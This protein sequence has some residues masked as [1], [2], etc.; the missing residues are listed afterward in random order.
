MHEYGEQES[1]NNLVWRLLV[2]PA[3][4]YFIRKYTSDPDVVIDASITVCPPIADRYRRER[5]LDPIIVFN[6]PKPVD[7]PARE[8]MRDAE[9]IRLIHHGFAK[10]GRGLHHLVRA[11]ALTDQRFVLDF[12][13][14]EDNPGYIDHLRRL[15][16]QLAPGR[17]RFRDPVLPWEIVQCVS[18]Y[19]V[20]LC[21]IEPS[22][23]NNLMMLPNKL[24]EYIQGGLA[25][26][27]GPSPA[28]VELVQRHR[29]GIVTRSFEPSDLAEALN[30][31]TWQQ[32][33]EMKKAARGA[34]TVLNADVEM[35]KVVVL[36]QQLLDEGMGQREAAARRL[37]HLARCKPVRR[38][39]AGVLLPDDGSPPN[40]S[41]DG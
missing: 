41:G 10:R 39:G 21:V 9:R 35:A 6:A 14:V 34:A 12:M 20:G 7:V 37:L 33:G 30:R 3:V 4:R 2:A 29:V 28:M 32:I 17:V 27:V 16:D 5:G 11:L 8:D 31:L 19:D 13:L 1:D 24:F 26:C 22:T 38:G 36:Y 15:A 23:Y 25:V 40:G 18:E